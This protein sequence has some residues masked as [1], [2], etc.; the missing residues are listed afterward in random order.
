M[1]AAPEVVLPP[2]VVEELMQ[3][4]VKALRAHQL[5]LPNNP[6]YQKALDTLRAAFKPVWESVDELALDVQENE[7]HWEGNVVYSQTNRGESLAWVFF[8][9][10]VRAVTLLPGVEQ[11]EIVGLL[12]VVHRARTLRQE[13]SDDLLTLLWEK[14]F[15]RIRYVFQEMGSGD[16]GTMVLPTSDEVAVAAGS[17]GGR[18]ASEVSQAVDEDVSSGAVEQGGAPAG[19]AGTVRPEDFDS[20]LYFL[21]EKEIAYL[22][23]EVNREYAQDLRRSVL[24][25]LLDVLEL[26]PYPTV[27]AELISILES[28]LPYL[29]GAGDY[30]AVAYVLR[31]VKAVLQRAR[32]LLAEHRKALEDLPGR[33][34]EAEPLSQLLQ[35]LDEAAAHPSA[36]ELGDLFGELRPEALPTLLGWMPKL[37]NERVKVVLDG[38]IGR[39]AAAH[40]EKLVEAIGGGD[41]QVALEAVK[42]SGRLKLA[43]AV[44][45]LSLALGHEETAVRAAA[46]QALSDLGVPGALQGL[47]KALEDP[48][49]EVR[50][51]TVRILMLKKHRGALAKVTAAIQGKSVRGA[52]LTEKM[53]FFEAY[54]SMVGEQGVA[55]LDAMLNS[56][57]FLKRRE[58]PELRACAALALGRIGT[59]AA[60]AALERASGAKDALVRNAV[61]RA[62]RGAMGS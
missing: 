30:S 7:L 42:L 48:D 5:Y 39:L 10:G 25:M 24:A 40:P 18:A 47:E 23:N 31:E 32:E 15:Q 20:T 56:G 57:G 61:A 52:D 19:P 53:A 9:D 41:P 54:G 34:S 17:Q 36:D 59:P 58:D 35:S 33:L 2:A 22:Q 13:D 37:N 55:S 50:L 29:L 51:A 60:R 21:D 44:P 3:A 1:G 38:A 16:S 12:D 46:V 14:D 8:K 28:F 4:T 62:R 45:A 11:D 26:Q 43:S 27:R 49:R 6:V